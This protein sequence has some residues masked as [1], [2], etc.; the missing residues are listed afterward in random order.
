MKTTITAENLGTR[1]RLFRPKNWS[2]HAAVAA[3]IS[4]LVLVPWVTKIKPSTNRKANPVIHQSK[5]LSPS[6]FAK[7]Q[8][9]MTGSRH[10]TKIEIISVT[11]KAGFSD[12][13]TND[14]S[15]PTFRSWVRAAA[16][17]SKSRTTLLLSFLR[18]YFRNT[19]HQGVNSAAAHRVK[20]STLTWGA[21][22]AKCS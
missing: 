9:E 16:G 2:T 5:L 8:T 10:A 22:H 6:T 7:T 19:L 12:Q 4:V 20:P 14:F 18:Q 15:L 1:Q 13:Y 11:L 21:V 17:F 3:K